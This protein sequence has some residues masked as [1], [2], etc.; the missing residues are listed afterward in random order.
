LQ[1]YERVLGSGNHM[2]LLMLTRMV[3]GLYLRLGALEWVRSMVVIRVGRQ[4]DMQL[5]QSI[6]H[7]SFRASLERGAQDD[8]Q[9][10]NDLTSR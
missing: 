7:A 4:R 2:T 3:L 5:H 1:A 6:Y 8:G 10:L 9:A